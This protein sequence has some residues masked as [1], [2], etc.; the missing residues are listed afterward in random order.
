M[1]SERPLAGMSIPH[2]WPEFP[3]TTRWVVSA[4][5]AACVIIDF[6]ACGTPLP[7]AAQ[8]NP[9]PSRNVVA[10][11][12]AQAG[13]LGEPA[14]VEFYTTDCMS[15][16]AIRAE[17]GVLDQR[18]DGKIKFIYFDADLPESQ[19]FLGQFNVRGVPT[20]ALLNQSGHVVSNMVGWPGDEAIRLALDGLAAP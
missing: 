6:A 16:R 4:V 14:L 3:E 8:N 11:Q 19:P 12:S 13:T 18:Y 10:M 15:C 20:L 2:M 17:M 1:K 5:I 9:P 7:Q